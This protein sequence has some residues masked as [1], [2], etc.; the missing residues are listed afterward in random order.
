M[1]RHTRAARLL[2]VLYAATLAESMSTNGGGPRGTISVLPAVLEDIPILAEINYLA[3]DQD[4][5]FQVGFIDHPDPKNAKPFFHQRVE[6]RFKIPRTVIYQAF[7]A[8]TGTIEGFVAMTEELQAGDEEVTV[9]TAPAL[10]ISGGVASAGQDATKVNESSAG[11]TGAAENTSDKAERTEEKQAELKIA[12]INMRKK[13]G[14]G[15]IM[16]KAGG[17]LPFL[18]QDMMGLIRTK[19]A[20]I[21]MNMKG[22]HWCEWLRSL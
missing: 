6:N 5:M 4:R 12:L 22:D 8:E 10:P 21:M 14:T 9:G 18:N 1:G 7:D 19:M 15:S 13:T 2:F 16:A 3:Y 11:Q 17:T 20:P